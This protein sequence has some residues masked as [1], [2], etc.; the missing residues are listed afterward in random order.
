M[1]TL[2]IIQEKPIA[3]SLAA[4]LEIAL[5]S[6]ERAVSEG[7]QIIVFG[8]CWFTGYPA[9]IDHCL[10]LGLWEHEPVKEVWARLYA[11]GLEIP[12][13]EV[14]Q[15]CALAARHEVVLVLGA[16]EVIRR[17]KG[18][19]SLY[20]TALIIDSKGRIA[21]HH[22]K[23]MPTYTERM[24]HGLGDGQGLQSVPTQYGDIGALICWEHWMPLA[25]QAMHDAGEQIH[26]A[27][28]PCVKENNILASR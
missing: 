12:G 22:R 2:A 13:P 25:R 28:W 20:N 3:N 1:P 26:V 14:E 23:L 10:D 15:L 11:N 21:N 5:A 19:G 17:G 27:L 4:C 24:I 18:N 6:I 9:W 7:A 16:N 8:E